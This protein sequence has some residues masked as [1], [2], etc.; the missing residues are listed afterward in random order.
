[1]EVKKIKAFGYQNSKKQE[2]LR[3]KFFHI[4]KGNEKKLNEKIVKKNWTLKKENGKY[5][6]KNVYCT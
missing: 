3:D 4:K 5:G 1:M 2:T 6:K